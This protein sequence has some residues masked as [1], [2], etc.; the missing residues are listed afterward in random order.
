MEAADRGPD[1]LSDLGESPDAAIP[2]GV[3]EEIR[4]VAKG[5]AVQIFGQVSQR[6]LS[7]VFQFVALAFVGRSLFGVY[8]QITQVLAIAAQL[9]IAGFN[10]ASMRFITKARA[11][12][13]P[14]GVKGAARV[15]LVGSVLGSV[16]VVAALIIFAEPL[17]GSFADEPTDEP[18]FARLFRIGAPY[19]PLFALLQVLRY[20]SQAYKTM[21]PSVISGN[22]VQPIVR[23]VVGF[24]LLLAGFEVAGLIHTLNV[25]ILVAMVV[26]AYLFVRLMSE[27]ERAATPRAPVGA[28]VRFA[29]PQG[30]SSLLGIQSLGLGILVVGWYASDIQVAI[31]AIALS[32]QGPG[33]VFLGGILNIWAPVVSDL[34]AKGEID[35]LDRLYKVITRWVATFSFPVWA[36]LIVMPYVFVDLFAQERGAGASTVVAILAAGNFFYT[37]TGP[38]GYVLSMTGRPVVNLI[39]SAVAVVLYVVAGAWAV[40]RYGA[41]GMAVVDAVVTAVI[42]LARVVQ[43]KILV[44][45]QPFG[46]PILKPIGATAIGAAALLLW[47]LIPGYTVWFDAAGIVVAAVIYVLVLRAFGMD[48]EEREVWERI[49]KRAKRKKARS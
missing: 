6:G 15:G 29:L 5:G 38:T 27:E 32:L 36:A 35:R 14:E 20:C 12:G 16:I 49:R 10:Y 25:S 17:A 42:N 34:H 39:N 30:G 41:E 7:F 31:F 26:A 45:V 48:P 18:L 8:K 21:T 37:G 40:P 33:T 22:V 13:K 28:M 47:R 24:A 44:G 1:L 4:T 9:A 19:V 11:E 3:G 23:F 46:R 43:A 2:T